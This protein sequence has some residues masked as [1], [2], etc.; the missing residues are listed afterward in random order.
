MAKRSNSAAAM[1]EEDARAA[2]ARG[3]GKRPPVGMSASDVLSD[4]FN[5]VQAIADYAFDLEDLRESEIERLD[6]LTHAAIEPIE[7]EAR[8]QASEALVRVLLLFRDEHPDAPLA[9]R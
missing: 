9:P 2:V 4:A 7:H 3:W 1:T 8:R 6:E 5:D